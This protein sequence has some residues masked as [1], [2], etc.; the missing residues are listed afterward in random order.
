MKKNRAK[1]FLLKLGTALSITALTASSALA[2][3]SGLPDHDTFVSTGTP[4][5]T[6]DGQNLVVA[7]SQGPGNVCS[8]TETVYLQWSLAELSGSSI[9]AATLTLTAT[10]TINTGAATISLYQTTD[11]WDEDTLTANGAPP[12]GTLIQTVNA[13]P[14]GDP[15]SPATIIFDNSNLVTYINSQ[16]IGDG[17]VSF[18]LRFDSCSATGITFAHFADRESGNDGPYLLMQNNNA[19]RLRTLRTTNSKSAWL[20]GVILAVIILGTAPIT[21]FVL[22]R[23]MNRHTFSKNNRRRARDPKHDRA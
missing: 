2:L 3:A 1:R 16:A 20:G 10:D 14:P 17:V 19:A 15:P 8:F 12:V 23:R 9:D 22:Q 4:A 6:H 21:R 5:A 11:G 7:A 13:P 18:A